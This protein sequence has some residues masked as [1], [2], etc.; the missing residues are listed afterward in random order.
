MPR[1]WRI[2][3]A[4]AKYHITS[5][6]NARAAVFLAEEDYER[7]L[8]QLASALERDEVI[9]YA[10]ALMPNHY[11]LL[12]ETPL[13]NVQR[14]M[15]R[16][17]TA[18][19]MYFRYKHSR[20][21]HCLQGR[22][23]AKLV[24]GDDYILRLTRY[25]HLNPVKTRAQGSLE[26][27]EKMKYLDRFRWSSCRGYTVKKHEEEAIDYRWLKL[28]GCKTQKGNRT[29]YR[30][31]IRECLG[32]E[33]EL[34]KEARDASRY[35]I[36]DERFREEAES[37]LKAMQMSKAL[38]GD[39]I[40]GEKE[41]WSIDEVEL[42]VAKEHGIARAE[43]HEHGHHSGLAKAMSIELC[44]QLTGLSQRRISEHYGYRSES[45][46]GKVRRRLA[47][48]LAMNHSEERKLAKLRDRLL[49]SRV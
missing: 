45:S 43:L 44:C 46:V 7:F 42:A 14:F 41:T 25:I 1:P 34:L 22:Y 3:Y 28:L 39:L 30:K 19:S 23:G 38:H 13:G 32:Q 12:I 17:N 15:Q 33:D 27:A 18:Y 40:L 16:L 48:R 20:P 26:T 6:G 10:Y 35:A 21:G 8:K 2:A 29:A 31:Y 4:G 5:R 36:G 11:H 49:K 9:L 24:S 37:D 47:A